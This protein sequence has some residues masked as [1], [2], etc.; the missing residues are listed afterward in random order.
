MPCD[1]PT[2]GDSFAALDLPAAHVSFLRDE[3][4]GWL[5]GLRRD[6]RASEKLKDPSRTER[7]AQA[8]ERLLVGLTVGQL[9]IPDPEAEAL[10][11]AAAESNDKESDYA[12]VAAAHDALHALL[13]VL[14]GQRN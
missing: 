2:G 14:G 6:L 4:T 5:D 7:E 12:E 9:L 1:N 8:V 3:M 11:R 13:D 10:L